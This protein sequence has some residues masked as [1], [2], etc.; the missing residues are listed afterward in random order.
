M[1]TVA[2]TF[3]SLALVSTAAIGLLLTGLTTPGPRRSGMPG[4]RSKPR[5][6]PLSR[7]ARDLAV[8]NRMLKECHIET[9]R[10]GKAR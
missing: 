9:F 1:K 3:S 4:Y 2:T 10:S 6:R 8:V 5:W 7:A